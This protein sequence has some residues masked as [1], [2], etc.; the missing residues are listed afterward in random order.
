MAFPTGVVSTEIVNANPDVPKELYRR[1]GTM[2]TLPS[3]L[4]SQMKDLLANLAPNPASPDIWKLLAQV[5]DLM[6]KQGNMADVLQGQTNA[7]M[8]GKL[9]ADASNAAASVVMFQTK[10]AETMFKY[11]A[12]LML[13][14]IQQMSVEAMHQACP[15]VPVYVWDA[16]KTWWKRGL[17]LDI[18]VEISTGG[19]AAKQQ[20]A[21]QLMAAKQQGAAVADPTI[22]KALDLDPDQEASEQRRWAAENQ[23]MQQGAPEGAPAPAV[24]PAAPAY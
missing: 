1:P 5:L 8:S 14:G 20:R 21:N 15:D 4:M 10:R 16:F 9:F 13:D 2:L 17:A 7:G 3:Q 19:G 22:L 24:A 6:D 12:N 11:L 18:G 23:P